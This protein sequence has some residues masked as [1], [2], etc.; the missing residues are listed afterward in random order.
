VTDV[1]DGSHRIRRGRPTDIDALLALNEE[2][3]IADGHR[4]D[5]AA[6]RAGFVPLLADDALGVVWVVDVPGEPTEGLAGY[7]AVTWG[8]SIEAG[9]REALLDEI[10]VR[11][12]RLGLG[13][14]MMPVIVEACRTAGARRIILETERAN[15]RARRFYLR[16]GFTT[17]DSIWLSLD[18]PA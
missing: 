9:G 10:Y 8:W 3:C 12:R 14:A 6:A 17:D 1:P 16:H 13:A 4:H 11:E 2:Y 5:A 18:L 7:V 15:D